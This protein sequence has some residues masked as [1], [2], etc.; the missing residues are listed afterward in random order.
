MNKETEHTLWWFIEYFGIWMIMLML[1]AR[2]LKGYSIKCF[3]WV[4]MH[5]LFCSAHAC[6]FERWMEELWVLNAGAMSA[7][8]SYERW[9]SFTLGESVALSTSYKYFNDFFLFC[10]FPEF[11]ITYCT[12]NINLATQFINW[13]KPGIQ[14]PK[15][16]KWCCISWLAIRCYHFR[17]LGL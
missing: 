15:T 5:V 17:Q 9:I 14:I 10:K 3:Y 8:C 13:H 4:D 1:N 11:N 16:S 2:V 12:Y 7:E 6:S